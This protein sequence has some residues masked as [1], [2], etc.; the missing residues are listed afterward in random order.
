MMTPQTMA[1]ITRIFPPDRRG[2][3]MGIWGAT[4]GVATLVGPILGGVLVDGLG[5]EW[6]FF[7]NV[8][9]GIAGFFLALRFVPALSTHPHKFDIP[10]VLLSAVGLFLLVFGIQE[11]ETYN[12]GTITG[13]VTVWGL[14]IAGILVLAAFVVWQRLNP[15][16]Q[17]RAAAAAGPVQG[18][19]LLAGQHRHH[20]RGLHRDGLQPAADLLL[21]DRPRA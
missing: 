12:W 1:V 17:G 13:P 20:H 6:I 11:G 15:R 3:A 8:P 14:I 4:A 5:W 2:A 18:P 16:L 21:P 7:I 10:G 19:Q 9:V